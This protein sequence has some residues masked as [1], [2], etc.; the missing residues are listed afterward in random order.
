MFR[1]RIHPSRQ[2]QVEEVVMEVQ[3]RLPEDV[4]VPRVLGRSLMVPVFPETI[5]VL[6]QEFLDRGLSG[7]ARKVID[8]VLWRTA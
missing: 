8:P 4:P 5:E 7:L 3:D 1:V 2:E 6:H